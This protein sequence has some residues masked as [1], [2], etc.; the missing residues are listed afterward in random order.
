MLYQSKLQLYIVRQIK[1]DL[2]GCLTLSLGAKLK[3]A[4]QALRV[5]SVVL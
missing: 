4:K 2:L 3:D 5:R 1:T